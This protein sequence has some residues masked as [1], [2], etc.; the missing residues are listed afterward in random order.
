MT[1]NPSAAVAA[2]T[3]IADTTL[4]SP[5]ASTTFSSIPGTYKHLLI[6]AQIQSANAAATGVSMR[7]NGDTAAN[8]DVEAAR[9]DNATLTAGR[10]LAATSARIAIAT[11]T[12]NAS[13]ASAV[14]VDIPDYAGTSFHKSFLWESQ[15]RDAAAN[16][17]FKHEW[18]GGLWRS[19]T[20]ISSITILADSG[21]LNTNS[22]FSLYG[23]S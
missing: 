12:N 11:G 1:Y 17:D 15:W 7:F 10:V 22:R 16:A 9:A 2:M 18:G 4:G 3:L 19:T 13:A 6:V 20:A 14:K 23:L 21:N 8:Y 5:A